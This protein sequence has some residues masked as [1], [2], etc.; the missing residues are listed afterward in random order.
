MTRPLNSPMAPNHP[1]KVSPPVT[2]RSSA[3]RGE[4]GIHWLAWAH[5]Q[6]EQGKREQRTID[7]NGGQREVGAARQQLDGD[8]DRHL[9]GDHAGQGRA[10]PDIFA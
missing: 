3:R 2:T 1:T 4:R 5:D 10:A 9:G 7:Q 8:R 6:R